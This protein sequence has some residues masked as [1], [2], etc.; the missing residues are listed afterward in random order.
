MHHQQT[1]HPG[2]R[3]AQVWLWVLIVIAVVAAGVLSSSI[4]A[5]ASPTSGLLVAVSGTLL[6]AS[7]ALAARVLIAL[8]RA[9]RLSGRVGAVGG[10]PD[11]R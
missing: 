5:P 1:R 10:R 2:A 11:E 4:A 3:R 8:E 7:I 6:V 9:R